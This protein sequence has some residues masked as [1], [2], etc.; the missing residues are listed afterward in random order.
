MAGGESGVA[1]ERKPIGTKKERIIPEFVDEQMGI[2]VVLVDSV[3]EGHSGDSSGVIIPDLAG[4]E[5]AIAVARVMDDFRLNGKELKF[6]RKA[7]GLKAVDLAKFLDVAPETLSRWENGKEAISTNAERVLR[8]R[9]YNG[10][11]SKAIGVKANV[12]TILEMNFRPVRL[13]GDGTMVFKYVPVSRDG[14]LFIAWY[15]EG[16]RTNTVQPLSRLRA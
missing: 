5:A 9:V 2:P 11:R 16:A 12:G 14:D 7:I 3:Y 13:A 10:L 4:L 8:M 1:M 15:H 6:L